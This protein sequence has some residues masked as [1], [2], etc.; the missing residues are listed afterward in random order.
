MPATLSGLLLAHAA[1]GV[2][3]PAGH[4]FFSAT[5]PEE[6]DREFQWLMEG[7]LGAL[8]AHATRD[9]PDVLP[10]RWRDAL[11]AAELTARVRQAPLLESAAELIDLCRRLGIEPTLLK[12]ISVS[13]QLYPAPHLRPMSDI[14]V[15]LPVQQ[16]DEVA[17]AL[18]SEDGGWEVMDFQARAG[19]HHG[20]PL[21]H[22]A[23]GTVLELHRALFPDDSPFSVGRLFAPDEVLARVVPSSFRGQ[24]VRRLPAELQLAYI[25]ASWFNDMTELQVHPS[26]LPSV[27]DAAY[28]LRR[29][30]DSLDWRAL[31]NWLD[32]GMTRGCLYA[33]L[34]Y[35]PRF[36]A[37]P[38]PG[39]FTAWLA[40]SQ[41]VVGPLQLRLIHRMLDRHLLAAR[42]WTLPFPPPVPGRYSL[43]HQWRKRVSG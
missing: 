33:L 24:P 9:E 35:L 5:A 16:H 2:P 34:S 12:G 41:D 11:R 22:R 28:L 3:L 15:L 29:F 31:R 8:L 42:P 18:T 23:R 25:A 20:A 32:D 38:A 40:A 36:G 30:G 21:R 4:P 27:F 19:L 6:Q 13:E 10:A 14:D 7:G 1:M 43:R 39:D 37:P 17:R 26:F